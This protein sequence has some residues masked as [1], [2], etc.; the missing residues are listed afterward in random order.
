MKKISKPIA[1]DY[2]DIY[3]EINFINTVMLPSLSDANLL[4]TIEDEA[5]FTDDKFTTIANKVDTGKDLPK[6]D[7]KYLSDLYLTLFTENGFAV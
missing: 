6:E 4:D 5:E 3:N 2:V 7:R 1:S